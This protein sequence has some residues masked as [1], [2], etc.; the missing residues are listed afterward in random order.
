MDREARSSHSDPPMST[1][2]SIVISNKST[3]NVMIYINNVITL[4]E[5]QVFLHRVC[6]FFATKYLATDIVSISF[7]KLFA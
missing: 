3:D 1:Y 6:D 2:V 5:E 7:G 4:D